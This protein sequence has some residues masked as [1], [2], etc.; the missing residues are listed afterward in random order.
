MREHPLQKKNVHQ[1]RCDANVGL[2]IGHLTSESSTITV[3]TFLV[4]RSV[5][6]MTLGGERTTRF[7]NKMSE[8]FSHSERVFI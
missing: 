1:G 5:D 6:L 3:G 2:E 4:N 7:E 8:E